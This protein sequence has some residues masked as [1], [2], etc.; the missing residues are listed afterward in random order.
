VPLRAV[1][2]PVIPSET[3]NSAAARPYDL[4]SWIDIIWPRRGDVA[5]PVIPSETC[6]GA[7]ARPY[8]L[9]SWIEICAFGELLKK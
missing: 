4:P 3:C 8:D 7:A 9:P 2:G 1:A 6:N 5:G